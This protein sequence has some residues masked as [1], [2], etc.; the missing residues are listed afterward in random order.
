[1]GE[2]NLEPVRQVAIDKDWSAL[3][4]RRVDKIKTLQEVLRFLKLEIQNEKV[5][6]R[7]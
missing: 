6:I 4:F 3:R 7:H 2:Y 1:L 5:K